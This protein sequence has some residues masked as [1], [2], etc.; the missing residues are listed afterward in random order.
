[1]KMSEQTNELFKAFSK[2]Q[3]ELENAT[4]NAVNPGVKNKYAD[5]AECI[6]T[7]KKPL[8]DNGLGVT[9][10]IGTS[11]GKQTLIT[12]LTHSSGQFI[13]SEFV[14]ADAVLMG[15]AGK[16]PVQAL[17]SAITYQRRY[18]YAAIIGMA[19]EDDD[20]NANTKLRSNQQRTNNQQQQ[21]V[22]GLTVPM[23]NEL[24]Q[25]IQTNGY[26]VES[27]CES[28]GIK[29]LSEITPNNLKQVKDQV[30]AWAQSA[31][32]QNNG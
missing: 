11:E 31:Q 7:A 14:M 2:F 12:M 26:T 3:G 9:Q 6:N 16:N 24:T 10:M 29:S 30:T 21:Q 15:G 22:T 19:Q 27:I 25:H 18:A 28:Y 5:L 32:G 20:G 23:I 13:S 8:A 17:G 1:M 4:K